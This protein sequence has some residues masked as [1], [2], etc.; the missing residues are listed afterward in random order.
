MRRKRELRELHLAIPLRAAAHRPVSEIMT[1][2]VVTVRADF[3]V[4]TVAGLFLDRGLHGAPVVDGEGRPVGFLAMTDLVRW[5]H[6]RGESDERPLK[7]CDG[8]AFDVGE[9][10]HMEATTL[11]VGEVMMPLAFSLREDTPIARA[12]ALLAFEGV[13]RAP[14]VSSR[15]KVVGI[16]SA[17]D[18]LRWLAEQDG[19]ALP[20]LHHARA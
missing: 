14:V 7:L 2:E 19:Y 18:L 1:R 9:G 6:E 10:F 17:L 12:A 13:H 5:A 4:E 3:D 11:T 8:M 16:V 20:E 15:G